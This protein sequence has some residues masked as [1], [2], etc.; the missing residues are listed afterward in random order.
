MA[1]GTAL[2]HTPM[3]LFNIIY[4]HIA[5]LYPLLLLVFHVS[6]I[7]TQQTT[8]EYLKNWKINKPNPYNQQNFIKNIVTSLCGPRGESFISA[9]AHYEPGDM[10]FERL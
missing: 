9:R 10:R 6:L 3:T 4:C 2:R 8:R 5:M 1:I 7:S